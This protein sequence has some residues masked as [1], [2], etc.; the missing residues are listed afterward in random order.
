MA[1]G[2]QSP[3]EVREVNETL[4]AAAPA[5]GAERVVLALNLVA[6]SATINQVRVRD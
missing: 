3:F 5:R 4:A 2:T 6:S 1:A